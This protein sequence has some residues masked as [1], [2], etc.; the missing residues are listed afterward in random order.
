[1]SAAHHLLAL[2]IGAFRPGGDGVDLL[3]GIAGQ[4][5]P[6][7]AEMHDFAVLGMHHDREGGIL[8]RAPQ[9][10]LALAQRILGFFALGYVEIE[11]YPRGDPAPRIAH[12]ASKAENGAP[13]AVLVLD[14]V[15]PCPLGAGTHA[16]VPGVQ[17]RLQV[18]G[19]Q[20]IQPTSRLHLV[21][22]LADEIEE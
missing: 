10:R 3:A 4:L 22:R 16:L 12:R 6:G 19:R 13:D 15:L 2:A 20:P 11:A 21:Q 18:L 8:H 7:L 9:P 5:Q 1:M 17:R 14:A